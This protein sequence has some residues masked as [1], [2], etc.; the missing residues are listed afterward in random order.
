M[1]VIISCKDQLSIYETDEI[2]IY[3]PKDWQIE[4]DSGIVNIFPKDSFGALTYSIMQNINFPVEMTRKLILDL[5]NSKDDPK[6]V[7]MTKEVDYIEFYYEHKE[8]NKYWVTKVIR[9]NTNLFLLTIN[10]TESQ[11][12]IEK[13]NYLPIM[14]SIKIK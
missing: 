5:Y 6:N 4:N 12:D 9:K 13:K 2:I 11:W 1:I 8:N 14:E 3:Y 7:K 10:C